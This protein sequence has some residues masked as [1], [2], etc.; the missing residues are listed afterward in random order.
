[1][2]NSTKSASGKAKYPTRE[3]RQ[4]RIRIVEGKLIEGESRKEILD[5]A[6]TTWNLKHTAADRLIKDADANLAES[7]QDYTRY[8]ST[9]L[10]QMLEK[11]LNQADEA[12]DTDTVIKVSKEIRSLAGLNGKA[13]SAGPVLIAVDP[14]AEEHK[15]V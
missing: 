13:N 1:M 5:Y 3:E 6:F 11:H 10:L 14:N 12:G 8:L 2:N 7:A 4:E 15:N 9:R